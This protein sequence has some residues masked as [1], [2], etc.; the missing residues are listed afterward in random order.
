MSLFYLKVL[1]CLFMFVDHAGAILFDNALWMRGVGR[2]ALP[3]FA[4]LLAEGFRQTRD[5]PGYLGRLL[6][7]AAI[8]QPIYTFAFAHYPTHD[9]NICFTLALSLAA[10]A[11]HEK[12]GKLWPVFLCMV[13]AELGD[14]SY[15]GSGVLLVFIL[16]RYRE[17]HRRL[18]I[19]TFIPFILLMGERVIR[20]CWKYP[21]IDSL[22][23]FFQVAPQTFL[24]PLAVL[25]LIFIFAWDGSQGP[26]AKYLFYAFYPAHLLLL[27]ILGRLL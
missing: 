24:Y 12:S 9:L 25:A 14:F 3:I 27:G 2:L 18:I 8:S 11:L 19:Y 21:Q 6:I 7:L 15:G 1:A 10:L 16:Y 20:I 13:A 5:L 4:F 26:R 23:D 22:M 17:D